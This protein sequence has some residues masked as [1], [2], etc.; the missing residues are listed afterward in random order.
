MIDTTLESSVI[1]PI[2]LLSGE[3]HALVY[4][5]DLGQLYAAFIARLNQVDIFERNSNL[6]LLSLPPVPDPLAR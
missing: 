5:S 4:S 2:R 1:R 3:I 6:H